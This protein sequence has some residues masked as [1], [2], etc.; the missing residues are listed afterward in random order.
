MKVL[1]ITCLSVLI[2]AL[3][4]EISKASTPV[5]RAICQVFGSYCQQALAVS[6]CES[7]WSVYAR[8]G[9]Y[10]GLFQMGSSE[11]ARYG[12]GPDAWSQARAAYSYFVDSGRT[13]GPW[14]CRP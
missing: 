9:Q 12:H 6:W 14:S 13:W 11:R 2:A 4:I 3:Q 10:L 7:R 5:K 1:V 8:N